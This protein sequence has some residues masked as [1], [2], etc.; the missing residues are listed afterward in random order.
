MGRKRPDVFD[1]AYLYTLVSSG[2]QQQ[3]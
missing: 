2:S 3:M 1:I